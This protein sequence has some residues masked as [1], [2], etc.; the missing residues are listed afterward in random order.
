MAQKLEDSVTNSDSQVPNFVPAFIFK[1]SGCKQQA[2]QK[3]GLDVAQRVDVSLVY[4]R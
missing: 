4:W 3:L 1:T 2:D